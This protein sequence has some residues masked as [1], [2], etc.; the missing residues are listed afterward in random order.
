M[1]AAN[2]ML[3]TL[4]ISV[5]VAGLAL[6]ITTEIQAASINS[7]GALNPGATVIDF[8]SFGVGT[9]QPITSGGLTITSSGGAVVLAQA[10][11]QFP[12]IFEGRYFGQGNFN[13]FIDFA[14]PVAQFGMGIFDPNFNG[15]VLR[16]LD[17]SNQVL[18]SVT[19]S[20]AA[21]PTGP[22]GGSFSTFVGFVRPSNDIKRIELLGA[23]GDLLGIDT[24]TSFAIPQPIPEPSSL[25]LLLVGIIGISLYGWQ[26]RKRAA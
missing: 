19:S 10:F 23:P 3:K 14:Q 16:A 21:F 11:T 8:E 6:S 17:A 13:Y 15:N 2:Y 22:T 25:I 5:V 26:C 7:P 4:F 18:E 9:P 24:V 12:G 1:K 20:S